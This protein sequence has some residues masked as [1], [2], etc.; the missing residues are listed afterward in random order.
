M[1]EKML[2][3][4]R[5]HS[6]TLLS[7]DSVRNG[8]DRPQK[9]SVSADQIAVVDISD[10]LVSKRLVFLG[11]PR[12]LFATSSSSRSSIRTHDARVSIAVRSARRSNP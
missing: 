12:T 1:A 10:R 2:N 9:Y 8:E 4:T 11:N 5:W 6:G 7:Y 3:H